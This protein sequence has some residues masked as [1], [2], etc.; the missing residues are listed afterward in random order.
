MTFKPRDKCDPEDEGAVVCMRTSNVQ[1]S[2]DQSDLI[3]I[4]GHLVKNPEKMIS[5]G[6]T[7]V[8]SANSWNLV[9][10]CC[11]VE[12]L[13]YPSTAGGFISILRPTS[14]E[15]DSDYLYRWFSSE[16]TQRRVRSFGNQTTNIANLNHKRTMKLRL[17]LPPIPKQKQIAAILDAADELRSKRR[18]ALAQLDQ[19]L[20]STFLDMF[21]DPVTNP[22]GWEVGR[23]GDVCIG[24]PSYGSGAA[25]CEYSASLPRYVRITDID[26]A[27]DLSDDPRSAILSDSDIE[28]YRL[29]EGDVLFAR[30]GATVGKSYLHRTQHGFCVYAGYLIRF[31][32]DPEI[33]LPE[34]LFRFA[35]TQAF[36]RW[37]ESHARAVAQPNINAKMY[38]ALRV[39]LPPLDL[40]RRFVDIVGSIER[41][42]AQHK[43]HLAELDT[44]FSSLQQRAFRGDL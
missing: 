6:D 25:A 34:V 14:K 17:P 35:H 22:M 30:S 13:Q 42:K 4:P 18:E 9:G 21:G 28:K 10:K 36:W 7:L 37:V 5:A 2:L 15:L 1:T 41:Q 43:V 26:E 40:Q 23:L 20:Q 44:L 38:S 3:A 27:G 16:A 19:L 8:S 12:D 11:R 31:R 39:I 32:P 29:S 33:L 24:K